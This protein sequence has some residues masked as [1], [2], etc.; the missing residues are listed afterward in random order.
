MRR[1]FS[2]AFPL[3]ASLALGL[4]SACGKRADPLAPYVK[5]PQ[6]PTGIEVSQI[7]EEIEVRV[8]APRTTTESRPLP[9]IELEWFQAAPL[10]DFGKVAVPILREEV[11]PGEIRTKRFPRP[12][13]EARFSVRAVAGKVRSTPAAPVLFKPAPVPEFPTDLQAINTAAGVL[14]SWTNP[15]GAEPW[16][17]LAPTPSPAPSTSPAAPAPNSKDARPGSP[18]LSPSPPPVPPVPSPSVL[19]QIPPERPNAQATPPAPGPVK[20]GATPGP[21]PTPTP[22]LLPPTGIRI[23]RTDGAP[24]LAREPLQASAWLDASSKPGEKPCYSLRYATSFKPLVE[25]APTEPACVETKDIVPPEPPGRL[26]GDIGATFV[27]LSWVASVS[28]DV[29]FYRIYRSIDAASITLAIETPGPILRI[30]DPNMARGPRT[31][32][33][34]A[35]DKAGNESARGPSLK[36]IVP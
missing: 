29:E 14:L 2:W 18:S 30:R 12:P 1:R 26:L 4:S 23:F 24:R 5:T 3:F 35:V 6:P 11:A 28:G 19:A 34:A 16:P 9:V 27:E 32:E 7:G 36:I 22:P 25:S 8:M 15:S 31:Y 21:V 33:I 17:T 20:S 10:G 13:V